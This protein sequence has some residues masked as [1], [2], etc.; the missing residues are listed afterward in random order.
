M[1]ARYPDYDVLKKWD[2]V[3][4][5]AKT[6]AVLLNR[7]HNVPPRRFF[8]EAE[9]TLLEAVTARLAPRPER[10]GVVP[11]TPWI[12]AR[13]HAHD[14]EGF[15]TE[16]QPPQE[17][18][19]RSGLAA[20]AEEAR[21]LYAR[22]F[23]ALDPD[24]QDQTLTRIQSG[25]VD[26]ERW[27]KVEPKSFFRMMLREVAGVYYAHPTAWS[28]IGFGGPASPRGYVRIGLDEHDPWE[29]RE[30]DAANRTGRRSAR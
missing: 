25:D 8:S 16:G 17:E 13:L 14:T 18:M 21:A 2:S 5:D 9:W 7:L 29:A 11:I 12:D 30:V 3:S 20:L 6:R 27:A 23:E 4:F 1:S 22:P 19:W 24:S 28:E 10:G 26:A 15:R